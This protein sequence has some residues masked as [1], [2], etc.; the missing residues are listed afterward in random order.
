MGGLGLLPLGIIVLA[1]TFG[2]FAVQAL[3]GW[4]TRTWVLAQTNTPLRRR[5]EGYHALASP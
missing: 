1:V 4:W 5:F 2:A 3:L